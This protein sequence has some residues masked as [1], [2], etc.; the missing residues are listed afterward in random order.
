MA[1]W[2]S[3]WPSAWP[4]SPA[5]GFLG[6]SLPI[7]LPDHP[8]HVVPGH[9]PPRTARADLHQ[10]L[11]HT[12]RPT[13]VPRAKPGP[14]C[15]PGA[16]SPLRSLPFRRRC[17]LFPRPPAP[18]VRLPPAPL[19]RTRP[20]SSWSSSLAG[21]P[22]PSPIVP[23]TSPTSTVS[24]SPLAMDSRTPFSS[25]STSKLILSVS[26]ST[27]GSPADTGSPSCF[28]HW[29]TVASV[30]D[31]PNSGTCISTDT[32]SPFLS[33]YRNLFDPLNSTR[34]RRA[35]VPAWPGP[36]PGPPPRRR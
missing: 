18:A 15:L 23:M 29:P 36:S 6:R 28:I 8:L 19:L 27:S 24:P 16:R 33:G 13:P 31:S 10:G 22:L 21:C 34:S 12:P 9:P 2:P 5:P 14:H 35:P 17:R 25:A 3:S 30:T 20:D 11:S 7:L 32:C 26:S 4:F 1:C